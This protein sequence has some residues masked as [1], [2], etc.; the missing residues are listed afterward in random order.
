VSASTEELAGIVGRHTGEIEGL[1]RWQKRQNGSLQKIETR[2]GR[3][4]LFLAI[5]I[6]LGALQLPSVE[7]A[8]AIMVRTL[9]GG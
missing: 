7:K 1:T 8:V 2:L 3:L 4:E 6:A 9:G 5:A